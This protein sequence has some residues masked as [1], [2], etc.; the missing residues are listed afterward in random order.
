LKSERPSPEK[1]AERVVGRAFG[2]KDRRMRTAILAEYLRLLPVAELLEVVRIIMERAER[3][4]PRYQEAYFSLIDSEFFL[5]LIGPE[6]VS[7]IVLQARETGCLEIL[8]LFSPGD[9]ERERQVPGDLE[10]PAGLEYLTLGEKKSLAKGKRTLLLEKLLFDPD[11][12]V[13]RNILQNPRLTELEVIRIASRRPIPGA[14]LRVIFE[15]HRWIK[16]YRVKRTLI[17]NPHTPVEVSRNLL[18]YMLQP[19]LEEVSRDLS[20]NLQVREEAAFLLGKCK[21][22]ENGE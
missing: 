16:R 13:I 10:I 5:S 22:K 6:R 20:L 21:R 11:P 4:V 19:D 1:N 17:L 9:P 18:G 3:K 14:V 12:S 8:R 2:V 7:E 15:N